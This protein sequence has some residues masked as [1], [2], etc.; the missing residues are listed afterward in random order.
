MTSRRC[1]PTP[2]LS[3]TTTALAGAVSA[4][5]LFAPAAQADSGPAAPSKD[6]R[7][8]TGPVVV[9]GL[10]QPAFAA[11]P[12]SWIRQELWVQ[13]ESD[14]DRDGRP[15]RVHVSLARP[16]ETARGVKVPVIYQDSPYYAGLTDA[17]N[18]SV[19]HELGRPPARRAATPPYTAP[20]TS[21]VISR[22]YEST[23]IPRGFAVV[24]S[25]SP[26][27]GLSEGC[28]TSGGRNETLAGK[29]V[30]DWLGGRAK[31]YASRTATTP[32]PAAT[33]TTGDVGMTGTSYNGTLPIAVASTGVSNLKAIVPVS[34]ISSWYDYYRSGG[35]VRAPGGY[36][37]EDLDVLADAVYTRSDRRICRPVIDELARTQDRATGD[38]SPVWAERD[39]LRDVSSL[40]AATLVAHGLSDFNVTARN[41]D[42]LYAALKAQGVPHQI[43]L[44]QGGHGGAPTDQLMNRWFTRY[45]QNVDNGVERDPRAWIV[46]EGAS[47]TSPTPYADWPDPAARPVVLQ[48]AGNGNAVGTLAQTG[49]VRS[50]Q[51]IVD[52]ASITAQRLSEV[53]SSQSRL[54]FRS[55]AL[56]RATRIS[57]TPT[58]SLAVQVGAAQ[59]NMTALLVSYAPNGAA[60]ILTRGWADPSN[61]VSLSRQQRL[62]P[63][64]TVNL[65]ITLMPKDSVI[66]A[67]SRL[68]L[69]LLSSDREFTIRPARGTTLDV[70]LARTQLSLPVV[71][72]TLPLGGSAAVG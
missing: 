56:G 19:D 3:W 55:A 57:G 17:A 6:G 50:T 42:R 68:G 43:Y 23:W 59:A 58:V 25:E 1:R 39:Y 22:A 21:P 10:S 9:D 12:A 32:L 38:Y 52:D 7:G 61:A 47:R 48:P 44:H 13:T 67:G 62:N 70:D 36:Q 20:S 28:P 40:R 31:A 5:L 65:Q 45:L 16:A 53:S 69:V 34:A 27:S 66:P 18:W 51:R 35:L 41:A 11:D 8:P 37:G 2:R 72:G 14:S 24:H 46:R 64:R 63:H 29:A 30:V 49:A 71:G 26:G 60:T 33:W 4:G 15:D 54:L